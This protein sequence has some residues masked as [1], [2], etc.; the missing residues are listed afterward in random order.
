[1]H[2]CDETGLPQR[3]AKVVRVETQLEPAVSSDRPERLTVSSEAPRHRKSGRDRLRAEIHMP[4]RGKSGTERSQQPQVVGTVVKRLKK[5]DGVE[6]AAGALDPE[7]IVVDHLDLHAST[8]S[9]LADQLAKTRLDIKRGNLESE[10][11][12]GQRCVAPSSS[13]VEHSGARP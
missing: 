6:T 3:L 12:Q 2:L 8:T 5:H 7:E 1:M 11:R 9:S 10:L 4:V 13:D